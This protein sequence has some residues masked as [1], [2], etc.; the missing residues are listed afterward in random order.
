MVSRKDF[1]KTGGMAAL[2]LASGKAPFNPK[3]NRPQYQSKRPAPSDRNFTSKAVEKAIKE[4]KKNITDPKLAWM[5]E[6]CF[7]NTLD[8]TVGFQIKAG[9]PDTF[10]ITGD[11]NAMWLR[12]SSAQVHP[13]VPLATEDKKLQ[14]MLAGVINRQT[15]CILIDPYANAFNK[16]PTGSQWDSDLTKMNPWLHERKWEVD[17]LCYPIRLAYDYWKTTGDTTPFDDDWQKAMKSIV[18]TFTV[19]QRKHGPGPYH[20]QR[21]TARQE[22]TQAGNG[23]GRPIV[24][25]G[26]ICSMF[27]PSDDATLYPFLIPSNLFAVTSLRQLAEMQLQ[28]KHQPTFAKR[29]KA[30]ADEVEKAVKNY[31]IIDHLKTGSVY[32]Y[33]VDGYGNYHFM[34]D[35][36]AP[37]LLSLPY[38]GY[39]SIDNQLYRRTRNFVLSKQNPYYFVGSA[40]KGIGSPH[41]GRNQI[42]PIS[43]IMQALT[44][45][46]DREIKSLLKMLTNTD[47]G[48]GFM[49]ESFNKN[50]PKKFTRKWFAWANTLFGELILT[51]YKNKPSLL[52]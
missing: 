5:F 14:Q 9:K 27:R 52:K 3:K 35:A 24:P 21:K 28:I 37:S 19:Q 31:A 10:V 44:S 26:M 25:V 39:G 50:N 6:N 22:D 42:W 38:M 51:L 17:S 4:V 18:H 16:K 32:A 30:L 12:D 36:N 20:F 46:N 41:T 13:Y 1:L 47:G 45:N 2:G 23:Y 7:P 49:H 33:E 11:I 43:I 48:T 40:G 29:C 15:K 34:D 8:T